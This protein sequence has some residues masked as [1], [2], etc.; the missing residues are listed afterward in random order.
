MGF[1][2]WFGSLAA[3]VVISWWIR[4]WQKDIDDYDGTSASETHPFSMPVVIWAAIGEHT[5]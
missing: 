3:V 2:L 4:R 1:W 5:G